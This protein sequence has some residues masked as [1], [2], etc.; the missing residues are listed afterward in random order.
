VTD[1]T[2][3][4]PLRPSLAIEA[5][6][7]RP[8]PSRGSAFAALLAPGHS[9]TFRPFFQTPRCV[10]RSGEPDGI[11]MNPIAMSALL[12]AAGAL[13]L[14]TMRRRLAPLLH[15]RPDIRWDRINERIETL[16]RFGLGQKRL[17]DKGEKFNGWA[18]VLVFSAFMVLAIREVSLW[19]VGFYEPVLRLFENNI[20][21]QLISFADQT[22]AVTGIVGLTMFLWNR[23]IMRK[24]R[25]TLVAEGWIILLAIGFV[26]TSDL[27][28]DAARS[29][30]AHEE[31]HWF[32]WASY[33]VGRF[34]NTFNI[35][36]EN[37]LLL[38]QVAFWSHVTAIVAFGNFLPYGKHFHIIT[39]LPTVFFR[40]L[41]PVGQLRKLDLENSTQFG[42][43]KL[44]DLSWKEMLDTYSCTECGRCQTHCPTYVTGKPLAHKELNRA[45]R[46]HMEEM[47]PQ[48]PFTLASLLK[49]PMSPASGEGA[50]ATGLESLEFKPLAGEGG[51]VPDETI[52]ACTTCGWCETACPVFI[53]NVPRI[54]DM[55]RNKVLMESSFPEEA[56][57]VF[58]GMEQQSNPWG[59]GSNK[60]ADWTEGLDVPV[61]ANLAEA[62]N[63]FEYLFF[64]GC[65]GSF[66]E[67]QKKVTRDIFKILK[68]GKVDFA[69]L[70][71]E[72]GC[73]GDSARRLGNEYL[74]QTLAQ[75]NIDTFKK[76]NVTKVI[77]Q[78]PHCFNTIGNEYSQF[79]VQYEVVHHTQL[80]N[81]LIASGRIKL[82]E[83]TDQTVTY[84]DSCYLARYNDIIEAPREALKAVP[85]LKILEMPRNGKEGFCCGAGGG[86]MWLEEKIGQRVNQNRV[87][88]AAATGAE[89]VAT[90]CPFCLTMIRD[91]INETDRGEKMVAKDIAE[92]VAAAMK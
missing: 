62:G 61:A 9:V 15:S 44:T 16:I 4:L 43:A 50:V 57:R 46:H 76:Y 3:W 80:I 85:K 23:I 90:G 19:A 77:T 55:R 22:V 17:V 74:F 49:K 68:E 89:V 81:E 40:R 39:G 78:C 30:A 34:L 37:L 52:W 18:H 82:T 31:F 25:L 47:G 87:N 88:E 84:H 73:N 72:E 71:T 21:G 51:V 75:T 1:G 26:L 45:I 58:T 11:L 67:R 28:F 29:A 48:M 24:E 6:I 65:A 2:T 83:G 7:M 66:D 41:P 5:R 60:R 10:K 59:V 54:I 12:L 38:S 79:D 56:A 91:G 35:P 86:R 42:T 8:R 13:F 36:E 70:G 92:I 20:V 32:T 69:I 53:E 64:V 63:K 27:L 14:W 33:G